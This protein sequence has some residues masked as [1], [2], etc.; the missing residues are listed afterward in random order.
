ME[1][2]WKTTAGMSIPSPIA[3]E[4]CSKAKT[5]CD[6]KIPCSRCN[7]KGLGCIA[8]KA[9]RRSRALRLQGPGL[10][11]NYCLPRWH[12]GQN[13]DYLKLAP[14]L[15]QGTNAPTCLP[16]GPDGGNTIFFSDTNVLTSFYG[17]A[18]CPL[19]EPK[20]G[21]SMEL[22]T[23]TE[24]LR[25][26]QLYPL[27]VTEDWK[28]PVQSEDFVVAA[29]STNETSDSLYGW[30]NTISP[31]GE[32]PVGM[33]STPVTNSPP[34]PWVGV[35]ANPLLPRN[36]T[37]PSAV[38]ASIQ[39]P[40]TQ[41]DKICDPIS[42]LAS[43]SAHGTQ[44][45][46]YPPQVE[47]LSERLQCVD[48]WTA[49]ELH[50][51][52]IEDNY[53]YVNNLAPITQESRCRLLNAASGFPG[54]VTIKTNLQDRNHNDNISDQSI[55]GDYL[56]P[57]TR[58]LEFFA[59]VYLSEHALHYWIEQGLLDI[60]ALVTE[61]AT[62]P[63]ALLIIANGASAVLQE[64]AQYLSI[65]LAKAGLMALESSPRCTGNDTTML[66]HAFV[67]ATTRLWAQTSVEDAI[68]WEMTSSSVGIL[69][70]QVNDGKPN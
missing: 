4:Q 39:A 62:I 2:T 66:G 31:T 48:S 61:Q 30:F 44:G 60:N 52:Q 68:R 34:S 12:L 13:L 28:Y 3:C 55:S 14:A 51:A 27:T 40:M 23:Q 37:D 67:S 11:D 17:S 26:M 57:S 35:R 8:R 47:R 54:R 21:F 69:Y 53:S 70:F 63:L 25:G 50:V 5:G 18:S 1:G 24:V 46:T 38:E 7:E 42:C 41:S 22:Q 19:T 45:S 58:V 56:F 64:D 36:R 16:I 33:N 29:A 49:L 9:R 15:C 10:L 59:R 43:A 32:T 65:C 20:P 6:K